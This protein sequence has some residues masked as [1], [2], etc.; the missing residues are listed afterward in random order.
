M[1]GSVGRSDPHSLTKA[2]NNLKFCEKEWSLWKALVRQFYLYNS[3]NPEYI[4]E[5][6][7][8]FEDGGCDDRAHVGVEIFGENIKALLDT[9]ATTSIIGFDG[10]KYLNSWNITPSK[11]TLPYCVLTADGARQD[12][13]GIVDL[14]IVIR[15][16][17]KLVRALI[18]PSL[19]HT[20]ILGHNFCK[21]FNIKVDYKS[22]TWD[23]QSSKDSDDKHLDLVDS[24]FHELCSLDNLS[25]EHR[26]KAEKIIESFK[27]ISSENKLGRTNCV[28]FS[29]DTGDS[30]PFKERQYTLSPYMMEIL[31]KELDEMLSLGVVEPS[32]S[33]YSSPVLLVKKS[34]GEYRFCF[35][36]RKLNSVTKHDSYPLP[37]IDRILSSLREANFISSI[38]LRK[39]FWQIPLDEASKEK[40]AFSVAG[41]GLFQFNVVPFG[42][43][44]AAQAQQ[45]LVDKI[46]GPKYEP[47]IF[48]YLDDII[49]VTSTF[50]HHI[51]LLSE[52]KTLLEAANLTINLGKCEFFKKSLTYLGYI[53]GSNG[54]RTDPDKIEAMINYPR[55]TN[56][57]EIKRFVGLCSWY[58]RF[59]KDF[60]TLMSPINDLLKGKRKKQKID[61]SEEA[62]SSFQKIK[63]ALVSAPILSQPD[64]SKKFVIQCDASDTGLGGVLTQTIDGSERVI[65]YASRTLSRSER[66]YSVTERECLSVIF[67]IEKFR[68]YVEGARFTVITDHYSLLWLN[69]LKNP[70]GKLARWAVRLRQHNFDLIHRKGASNIVPDALSRIPHIECPKLD[71]IT[72]TPSPSDKW[73]LS[74]LN[75][76]SSNP[77]LYPQWKV[78]KNTIYKFF[79]SQSP[80]PTNSQDWKL[81]VP[82]SLR[83]S[84][85]AENH[86]PPTSSH[87]GFYK[88]Y[89]RLRELYYW[90]K[91][92]HDVLKF[93]RSCKTCGA[94]KMSNT[95]R[96]GIM[97]REKSVN[98]PFQILAV[99]LMG[100]FPRSAKG[101]SYLLVVGDWFS[102][103][104]LLFPMRNATA[105]S[106]I[107]FMEDQVFLV[108]GVPQYIIADNGTQ[109]AGHV[110]KNFVDKYRVQKIWFTPRYS[111]QCNFVERN[112]QTVGR[113]IRSYVERHQDWDKEL[114]KIQHAINTAKHEST[115]YSP[116]Y[117]NFGRH[118]PLSGDYYGEVQTTVDVELTPGDR[119]FYA[120]Q[121]THLSD[122]FKEVRNK[123]HS[124]YQRNSRSYNLRKRDVSF[125]EGDKVWRRNKVLSSAADRFAAK[126]APRYVLCTVHRKVSRLVYDL[127]N[128][129][130]SKAGQWHIKDLK[131]YFGSNSDVSVG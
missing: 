96:M 129:D 86:N 101:N 117:L 49:I 123:L 110:F 4:V 83:S 7:I 12:V 29:I 100:P 127:I 45:R 28:K 51:Q 30:L 2:N 42:L 37:R 61:W 108:Y 54:L 130:G 68:P 17:Q 88:T 74:L 90:P 23:I 71:A 41:R 78:E 121:V 114:P 26:I 66:N 35:D 85:I 52:V 109:F 116:C 1:E 113:A 33:P 44:N 34:S 95:A 92:R 93:V 62:E 105:P 6:S 82:N 64:F 5:V 80:I 39:A 22:E 60:S 84:I 70:T 72:I 58:K 36:G 126:L 3:V 124:A 107:K 24:P 69:N 79:P 56:T 14:P 102:K 21:A 125:T 43:C 40:T 75:K 27:E 89:S 25:V 76:I 73:Y 50:E 19:K 128:P 120:R 122:I 55:P 57:T 10:L 112:N 131:P 111:P 32:S 94:H 118:I 47:N 15:K 67:S 46:F 38:D 104:T 8:L 11:C 59:I 119:D 97:G 53:V 13:T 9:G 91:M 115:G 106:I 99:D 103:F 48:C 98:F 31:N 63:D 20:F 16:T 18:V 65:A 77:D 81:V 87:F